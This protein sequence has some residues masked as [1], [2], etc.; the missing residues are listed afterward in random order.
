MTS[1]KQQTIHARIAGEAIAKVMQLFDGTLAQ[2]LHEIL[3][4]ARRSGAT[5]VAV[6]H[7]RA[8]RADHRE[9]RRPGHRRPES[10]PRVR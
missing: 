4:N 2:A 9:R 7:E 10:A 8:K 5:S 1:S 6:T 3:Q